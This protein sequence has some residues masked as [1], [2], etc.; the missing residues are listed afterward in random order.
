MFSVYALNNALARL[1]DVSLKVLTTDS[2][3]PRV[4]DRLNSEELDGLYPNQQVVI[5]RRIAGASVSLEL[6]MRLPGLVRWADV[7]HLTASYSFPTIPTLLACRMLRKPVVWSPRGAILDAH[8]WNGSRKRLIKRLW[9]R[10]CNVLVRPGMVVTHTTSEREQE[11]TQARL[12]KTYAMVIP[13]GVDVQ[14]DLASREWLPNGKLR[15]MYLGRLSPKKGI[16]NLLAAMSKLEDVNISLT[17]YGSGDAAYTVVLKTQADKLGLL[18]KTVLF[19]G[20]VDDQAKSEAFSSADACVVP[21]YTEN[22]CMVV[23]EALA[24]GVPVIASKGTPWQA[25]EDKQCGLWVENSPESLAGAIS[26]IRLFNLEEMGCRGRTWMQ[27]EFGWDAI[28]RAMHDVYRKIGKV[29][30]A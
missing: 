22:F 8:E 18:G 15:L 2:A 13:N 17:I 1:S 7:V 21:S 4:S 29:V 10:F 16:E 3:G 14:D 6:L 5:T 24:H 30:R 11:V 12:P 26:R 9:E 23:A 19:A 28:A 27:N 20:Q 25:I